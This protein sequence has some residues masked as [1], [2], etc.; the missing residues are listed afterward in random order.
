MQ[1]EVLVGQCRIDVTIQVGIRIT[2]DGA[3][4]LVDKAV[5]VEVGEFHV[6]GFEISAVAILLQNVMSVGQGFGCRGIDTAGLIT[7]EYAYRLSHLC[8]DGST[9]DVGFY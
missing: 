8:Q 9:V 1:R 4:R 2:D 6:A 3:V 7:I 5:A